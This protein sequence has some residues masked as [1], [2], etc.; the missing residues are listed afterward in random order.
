MAGTIGRI[1][2]ALATVHNENSAALANLNFDFTLVRLDAPGEFK[3]LGATI[4]KKRK[5]DAEEGALH[6]SARRLGALFGD[7]L[8]PTDEL[9]RAYGTRVS[10]ISS[11]PSINPREGP[12]ADGIFANHIGADTASIWAAVTSGSAA[13]AV[14]LLGCMLARIFTGLEAISVWVE[15]VQRQKESI[16]AKHGKNLYSD[17]HSAALTAAKQDISRTDLS[18]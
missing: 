14:H 10:E 5:V 13:I 9:F 16:R 8:P 17:E 4:S 3:A 11:M 2:T 7:L 15:L 12:E 18:N 6:K 1:T